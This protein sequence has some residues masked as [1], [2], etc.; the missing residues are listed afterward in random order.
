MALSHDVTLPIDASPRWPDACVCCLKIHPARTMRLRADRIGWDQ[1][2]TLGWAVGLRPLYEVPACEACERGLIRARRLRWAARALVAVVGVL[3]AAWLLRAGGVGPNPVSRWIIAFAAM[4]LIV[5][6]A[7][8]DALHPL[9]IDTTA[10]G[11]R[12]DF[13]FASRDYAAAFAEANGTRIS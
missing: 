8:F 13:E 6:A 11:S 10:R 3:A 4:I 12:I 2:I 5:P 7:V 1:L 9:R